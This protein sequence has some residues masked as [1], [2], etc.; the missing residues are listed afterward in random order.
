MP[1]AGEKDK[2]FEWLETVYR[3]HDGGLNYITYD[4]A[5]ANLRVHP[6]FA[7]F[8]RKIKPAPN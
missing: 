1:G 4:R 7:A 8:L 5:I 6:R 3:T 2:A